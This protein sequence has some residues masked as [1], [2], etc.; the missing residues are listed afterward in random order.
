MAVIGRFIKR[1]TPPEIEINDFLSSLQDGGVAVSHDDLIAQTLGLTAQNMRIDLASTSQALTSGTIYA[2]GIWLPGS[3][4]VNNIVVR[5]ATAGVGAAPTGM[6]VGLL[7]SHGELIA[8]SNNLASSPI[9]LS[10]GLKEAPLSGPITL[11]DAEVGL[12]YALFLQVGAFGTT[13]VGLT[14]GTNWGGIGVNGALAYGFIGTGASGLP[15]VGT[16]QT[17]TS[18]GSNFFVGVD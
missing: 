13:Q 4:T 9:W 7:D 8:V 6:F 14:R 10:T 5:V 1:E 18:G 15:A 2:P 3:I 12:Y 16:Q 11:S 17:V